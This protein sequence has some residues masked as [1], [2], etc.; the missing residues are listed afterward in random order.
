MRVYR[1]LLRKVAVVVPIM[2]ALMIL[3]VPVALAAFLAA[4]ALLATRRLRPDRIWKTI[5]WPLLVF[6]AGLFV[7][8]GS[9]QVQGVTDELFAVAAPLISER[10]VVFGIVTAV[11][12]NLISNVP[13]VLVLQSLIP[14][15]A[16]PERGWLMLA[17]ASTLAG[18]LT[19]L[20]SVANL[21]VA[22]LAARW[23]VQLTFGAYLRAGVPITIL[24]LLVA[25]VLV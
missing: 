25:F 14:A 11:L 12:S 3:G 1:P 7:V 20:G 10:L 9:L 24:T 21:I 23:G 18:N 22:E 5:D 13:A 16:Q 2:L 17:A 19:L 6:F 8:T 15:L 4:A